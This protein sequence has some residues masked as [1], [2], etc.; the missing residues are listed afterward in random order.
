[1]NV[2]KPIFYEDLEGYQI[3]STDKDGVSRGG[4]VYYEYRIY[5]S[6]LSARSLERVLFSFLY[7]CNK[8]TVQNI[9]VVIDNANG[10][11]EVDRNYFITLDTV[12]FIKDIRDIIP[13]WLSGSNID[14]DLIPGW[15]D[16]SIR[17]GGG[18]GAKPIFSSRYYILLKHLDSSYVHKEPSFN[19]LLLMQMCRF[20][21]HGIYYGESTKTAEERRWG[22]EEES[23]DSLVEDAL[24]DLFDWWT[25]DRGA[26][27]K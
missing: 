17:S 22:A 7:F 23:I 21:D 9:S 25:E 3:L 10:S 26:G 8:V 15:D 4:I 11:V 5:I 2:K 27:G 18:K 1:M 20:R 24:E 16:P 6:D 12:S 19:E 13:S 14:L